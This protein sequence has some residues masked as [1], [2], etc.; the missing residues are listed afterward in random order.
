MLLLLALAHAS[1]VHGQTASSPI[2]PTPSPAQ[3]T[4]RTEEVESSHLR[5]LPAVTSSPA[6]A[7]PSNRKSSPV[8]IIEYEPNPIYVVAVDSITSGTDSFQ[9]TAS[10]PLASVAVSPPSMTPSPAQATLNILEDEAATAVVFSSNSIEI[11]QPI[12]DHR[13]TRRPSSIHESSSKFLSHQVAGGF[14]KSHESLLKSATARRRNV[15]PRKV[16]Y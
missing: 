2:R 9:V 5:D 14:S 12:P 4:P 10:S 1:V 7:T 11:P 3:A 8:T 16:N 6:Q 13:P 15:W